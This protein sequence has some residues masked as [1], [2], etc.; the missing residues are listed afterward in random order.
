VVD[1][2]WALPLRRVCSEGRVLTRLLLLSRVTSVIRRLA[3]ARLVL[4]LAN[5]SVP[6]CR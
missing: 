5:A 2:S 1:K 3:S 6:Q 4:L